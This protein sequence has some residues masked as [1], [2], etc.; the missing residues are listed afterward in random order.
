[1]VEEMLRLSTPTAQ[2]WRI[3]KEDCEV[4]GVAIP[5]GATMMVKFHSANRDQDVFADPDAFKVDR[6]N[7]KSQI[8][9][10]QGVHHCL[11]APLARQ[12]LTV[13]FK[14][15]LER[16]TR[17][18]LPEGEEQLEFLPSLLLHPPAKLSIRF[19]SR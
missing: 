4:G 2:M 19:E 13:G 6:T 10:G 15:I 11:G 14:V 3:A 5:K 1:M 18:S 8:A 7:L 9:F 16:M 12:E 17:F